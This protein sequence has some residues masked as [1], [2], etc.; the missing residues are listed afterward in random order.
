MG[1]VARY[2]PEA[3]GSGLDLALLKKG[4]HYT[5]GNL[6]LLLVL[7]VHDL[8]FCDCGSLLERPNPENFKV[9]PK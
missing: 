1:G 7:A 4:M 2:F 6:D 8:W 5:R 9:A 3:S